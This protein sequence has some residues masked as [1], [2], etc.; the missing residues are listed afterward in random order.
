MARAI[1]QNARSGSARTVSQ[2]TQEWRQIGGSARRYQ[3]IFV[4]STTLASPCHDGQSAVFLYL[5][6]LEVNVLNC[7]LTELRREFLQFRG[8]TAG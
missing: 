5:A 6:A 7:V 4:P 8:R 3:A 1:Q 2:P